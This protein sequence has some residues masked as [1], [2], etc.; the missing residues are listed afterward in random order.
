MAFASPCEVIVGESF[1]FLKPGFFV[2]EMGMIIWNY[3][4]KLSRGLSEII[5]NKKTDN[6]NQGLYQQLL[7][8]LSPYCEGRGLSAQRQF[9]KQEPLQFS[10]TV[11]CTSLL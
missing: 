10:P 3:F 6:T 7:T 1:L 11:V 5:H 2:C 9:N 4:M 8:V